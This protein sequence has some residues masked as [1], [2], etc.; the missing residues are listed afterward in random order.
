MSCTQAKA[1]LTHQQH[2]NSKY[3]MKAWPLL[4]TRHT[5]FCLMLVSA[6]SLHE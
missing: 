1:G 6:A 3:K 5:T 2:V 4:N